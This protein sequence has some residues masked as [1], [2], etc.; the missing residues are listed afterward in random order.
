MPQSKEY[1]KDY[2]THLL[3]SAYVLTAVSLPNKKAIQ[4]WET[5]NESGKKAQVGPIFKSLYAKGNGNFS[6]V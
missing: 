3:F 4:L 1:Y 5:T 2:L 6:H